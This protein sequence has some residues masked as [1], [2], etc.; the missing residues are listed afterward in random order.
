MCKRLKSSIGLFEVA[1]EQMD[2]AN[3]DFSDAV[4]SC[5]QEGRSYEIQEVRRMRDEARKNS[6]NF[7]DFSG[8]LQNWVDQNCN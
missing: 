3:I 7:A 5:Q 2:Y 1:I 8:Q 4:P 6:T